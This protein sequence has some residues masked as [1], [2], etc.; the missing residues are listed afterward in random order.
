MSNRKPHNEE[1]GYVCSKRSAPNRGY[2]VVYRVKDTP[3][4]E[5][6]APGELPYVVVCKSHQISVAASS[7]RNAREYM[8]DPTGWCSGCSGSY[9]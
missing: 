5:H 6:L 9:P 8:K 1:P 7:E 2:V 4:F 3:R